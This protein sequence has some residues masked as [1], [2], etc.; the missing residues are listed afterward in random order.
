MAAVAHTPSSVAVASSRALSSPHANADKLPLALSPSH[1]TVDHELLLS[2][3]QQ[4]E[5]LDSIRKS[6]QDLQCLTG[7]LPTYVDL[8]SEPL[9]Q[10][11]AHQL[12]N[13]SADI[14]AHL[15]RI[16]SLQDHPTKP[17]TQQLRA[18]TQTQTQQARRSQSPVSLH[19]AKRP[20]PTSSKC[21]PPSS[22]RS[23]N[24]HKN[25]KLTCLQCGTHSTPEWRSGPQGRQTLCN[26]CGL[27]HQKRRQR[28]MQAESVRHSERHF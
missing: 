6:I 10:N 13:L 3:L 19:A 26:V 25:I 16:A 18:H 4:S 12:S 14:L 11:Q 5:S 24:P 23:H 9:T 1:C 21:P 22:A 28:Q 8:L 2:A 27:M 20:Y 15:D 17:S 7:S